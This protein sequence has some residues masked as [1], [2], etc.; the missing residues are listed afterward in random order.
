M[1]QSKR[2]AINVYTVDLSCILISQKDI[3]TFL[4]KKQKKN[5]LIIIF[6]SKQRNN[7]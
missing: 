3:V 7:Q 5:S 2:T 1:V 6:F 4:V